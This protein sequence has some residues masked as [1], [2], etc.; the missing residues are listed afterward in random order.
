MKKEFKLSEKIKG[1]HPDGYPSNRGIA[2]EDIKEFIKRLKEVIENG[3][4]GTSANCW[5]IKKEIDKLTGFKDKE[6]KQNE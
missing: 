4:R 6:V 2:I 3:C 1:T 5:E